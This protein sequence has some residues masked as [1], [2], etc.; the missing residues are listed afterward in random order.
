MASKTT[1]IEKTMRM[2]K[3]LTLRLL[4]RVLRVCLASAVASSF[5]DSKEMSRNVVRAPNVAPI[6]IVAMVVTV[7]VIVEIIN[8]FSL[9]STLPVKRYKPYEATDYG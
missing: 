4:P 3:M 7:V 8:L 1:I 9:L 5:V 2:G 6:D